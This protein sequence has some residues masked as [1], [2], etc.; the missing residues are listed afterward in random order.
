MMTTTKQI[1]LFSDFST[2]NHDGKLILTGNLKKADVDGLK[3]SDFYIEKVIEIWS[4]LIC[5]ENPTH[6]DNLLI[7]SNSLITI[8]N[9]PIPCLSGLLRELIRSILSIRILKLVAKLR[10][11]FFKVLWYSICP[12]RIKKVLT[13][14]GYDEF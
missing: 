1:E 13:G 9:Q 12:G 14:P 4:N 7:W 6:F 11:L 2:S 5:K 3:I 10:P 8:A